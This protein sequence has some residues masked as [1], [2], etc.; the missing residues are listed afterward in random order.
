MTDGPTVLDGLDA[1]RAAVGRDLGATDWVE[2]TVEQVACY[3]VATGDAAAEGDVP[4]WLLLSLTNLFLPRLLEVRG[5]ANGINYGTGTVRFPG[6]VAV[7]SRVRGRAEVA[8]ADEVPGG[9][10]TTIRITVEAEGTAEAVCVVDSLS[11]WL[12]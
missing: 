5:V 4:P 1:V 9:V 11:R 6:P 2:V 7:G 8:A 10:Q 3:A 12:A